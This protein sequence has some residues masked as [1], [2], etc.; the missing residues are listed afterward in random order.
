MKNSG[1][2]I[3]KEKE[4]HLFEFSVK[5]SVGTQKEKGTGLGL[6][7]C[8]R[9]ASRIGFEVGYEYSADGFNVFYLEK[10]IISVPKN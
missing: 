3:P 10:R 6:G 7:L 5:S 4:N 9:I 1:A 8:K 2:R